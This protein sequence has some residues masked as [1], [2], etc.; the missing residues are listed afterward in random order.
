MKSLPQTPRP[1][2]LTNLK[3][4]LMKG[5][6]MQ[7]LGQFIAKHLALTYAFA[8]VLI[9]LMIVEFF[10]MRR[11]QVNINAAQA[12]QLINRQNAVI[13]DIRASELFAKG[14][15]IDALSLSAADLNNYKKIEKYKKRPIIIVCNSGIESQKVAA[16]LLKNGYNTFS[17]GIR[18]W[19]DADLPLIKDTK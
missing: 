1:D 4:I 19:I 11:N 12:V 6:Y 16:H 18:T 9:L 14:H 10:R 3:I 13:I 17:L 5:L 8:L 7:D 15:I 2:K